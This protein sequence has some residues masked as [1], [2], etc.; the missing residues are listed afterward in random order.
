MKWFW[1][2]KMVCRLLVKPSGRG[3]EFEEAICEEMLRRE[4][5]DWL[6]KILGAF[7]YLYLTALS[8]FFFGSFSERLSWVFVFIDALQEPYLGALGIYVILK[9]VR[10]RR[11][12]YPSL[13][14]GE[15]FV[16]LWV[17]ILAVATLTVVVSPI[18]KF[19][20]VYK[21]IFTSSL[22]AVVIYIGGL[23]NRP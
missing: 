5:V 15:L 18:H 10:K 21:V 4:A 1:P 12:D 13:Y 9:E 7:T 23:I 16:I 20:E 14:R 6:Y 8:I 3:A 2:K 17:I 11:R 19:D 22:A